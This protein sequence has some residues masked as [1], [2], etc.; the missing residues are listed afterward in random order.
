MEVFNK[1]FLVIR[2]VVFFLV[3]ICLEFCVRFMSFGS[4][5]GLGFI[6]FFEGVGW[7]FSFRGNGVL[8]GFLVISFFVLDVVFWGVAGFCFGSDFFVI[9]LRGGYKDDFLRYGVGGGL[10]GIFV[11]FFIEVLFLGILIL[12][13]IIELFLFLFLGCFFELL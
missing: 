7:W 11:F 12:V 13:Y 9:V 4:F 8:V 3:R 6:D 1:N 5:G 10:S 2:F